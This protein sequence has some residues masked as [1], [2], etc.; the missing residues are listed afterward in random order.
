MRCGP[1]TGFDLVPRLPRYS[2]QMPANA[3]SCRSSLS[4]NQTTSFFLVCGFGS[5]AYSAKR[6]AGTKHR[7]SGVRHMRQC[8]DDLFQM[9]LNSRSTSDFK[10]LT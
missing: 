7:F 5:D 10:T 4:A 6:L 2:V 8:G 1:G 9:L 3:N